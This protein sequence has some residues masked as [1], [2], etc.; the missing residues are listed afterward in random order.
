[1]TPPALRVEVRTGDTTQSVRAAMI[2]RPPNF[3]VTTPESCT[4]SSRRA[5]PGYAQHSR[6]GH[7]RRD[8]RGRPRQA[9]LAS[10][11]HARAPRRVCAT[12]RP[13]RIGLSAT[14][15][16]IETVARLLVGAGRRGASRRQPALRHRGCRPPACARGCASSCPTASSRRLHRDEQLDE[17]LDRIAAPRPHAPHHARLRQHAANVRACGASAGERLG[18]DAV[19]AH[20]GSL[21]QGAPP[22]GRA[23]AARRRAAGAGGDGVA[24]AGHR[25]RAGR[26]GVPDRLAAQHRHVPAA[27]RSLRPQPRRARPRGASIR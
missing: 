13:V 26:A 5:Q 19:A 4:C 2:R 7:R 18:D 11:R 24:G 10:G 22:A 1:M 25:H 8:P 3:L 9:R 23:Q 16:P 14:Q 12:Q 6:D 21:S 17:V 20:H 27:G 15:R